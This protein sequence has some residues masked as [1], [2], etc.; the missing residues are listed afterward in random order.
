MTNSHIFF[1]KT[2]E[3]CRQLGAR[4]GRAQ[5]RNRR[6]RLLSEATATPLPQVPPQFWRLRRKP[7]RPCKEDNWGYLGRAGE[8]LN[9]RPV[10]VRTLRA[11]CLSRSMTGGRLV[12]QPNSQS[13][14]ISASREDNITVLM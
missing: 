6:L 8:L 4:G 10:L 14:I 2:I 3:Q 13:S 9:K 11:N 12:A 1:N 7:W 5:A